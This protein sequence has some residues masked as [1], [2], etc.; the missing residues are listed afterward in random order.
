MLSKE[1][2]FLIKTTQYIEKIDKWYKEKKISLEEI[3]VLHTMQF[4]YWSEIYFRY[5]LFKYSKEEIVERYKEIKEKPSKTF[6]KEIE[7]FS[8]V[9]PMKEVFTFL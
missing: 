4:Y 7:K 9:L 3:R 1:I 5:S 6:K 2:K 8:K